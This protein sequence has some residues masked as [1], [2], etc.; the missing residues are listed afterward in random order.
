MTILLGLMGDLDRAVKNRADIAEIKR[1]Y[2]T[3]EI[4]R[5]EAKRLADPILE[6]INARAAEIARRHGKKNYPALGF[7]DAMRNSY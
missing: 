7:V 4:D 2:V 3:G 1:R 5:E 6:R